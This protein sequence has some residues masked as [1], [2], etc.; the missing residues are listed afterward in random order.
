M[1]RSGLPATRWHTKTV[2]DSPVAAWPKHPPRAFLAVLEGVAL[3]APGVR[4]DLRCNGLQN[5]DAGCCIANYLARLAA[6][7]WQRFAPV[8]A[9]GLLSYPNSRINGSHI[10]VATPS[11]DAPRA[12]PRCLEG[13]PIFDRRSRPLGAAGCKIS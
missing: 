10:R 6:S 1:T 7:G 11:R 8:V 12:F 13:M 2:R 3:L 9:A 4:S 5:V